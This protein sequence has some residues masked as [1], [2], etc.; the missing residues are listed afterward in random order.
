MQ[1]FKNALYIMLT[2]FPCLDT[3]IYVALFT[4][5]VSVFILFSSP[6]SQSLSKFLHLGHWPGDVLVGLTHDFMPEAKQATCLVFLVPPAISRLWFQKHTSHGG[7]SGFPKS[8][9]GTRWLNFLS[10]RESTPTRQ[11]V[12]IRKQ[13]MKESWQIAIISLLPTRWAV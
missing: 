1:R 3:Y 4:S 5:Y 12:T 9:I 6:V 11:T 8:P 10:V 13:K 7:V 2:P